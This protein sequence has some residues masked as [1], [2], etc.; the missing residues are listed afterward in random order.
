MIDHAREHADH[1]FGSQYDDI[2]ERYHA[3]I[4]DMRAYEES[5]REHYEYMQKGFEAG[6]GDDWRAYESYWDRLIKT[7]EEEHRNG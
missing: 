2:R 4:Q 6:F 3:E 7:V 5:E 1:V